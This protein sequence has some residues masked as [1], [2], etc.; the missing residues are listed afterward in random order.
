LERRLIEHNRGKTLYVSPGIPWELVYSKE[1]E[2]RSEAMQ[3]EKQIMRRG[4]Q[5]FLGEQDERVTLVREGG[6]AQAERRIQR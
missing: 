2:T 6:P 3:M 1:Y 5:R 4:A